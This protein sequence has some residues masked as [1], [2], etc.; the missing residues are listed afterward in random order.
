M[1]YD[2]VDIAVK[3]PFFSARY[4]LPSRDRVLN[5]SAHVFANQRRQE[6][7]ISGSRYSLTSGWQTGALLQVAGLVYL[8]QS[9]FA[10]PGLNDTAWFN[11]RYRNPL[12][13]YNY[14]INTEDGALLFTN[15]TDKRRPLANYSVTRFVDGALFLLDGYQRQLYVPVYAKNDKGEYPAN[16]I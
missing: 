13:F 6:I 9:Y 5:Q 3:L 12:F 7:N 11:N 10:P 8:N 14:T 4:P 2:D 15:G 1:G 16:G